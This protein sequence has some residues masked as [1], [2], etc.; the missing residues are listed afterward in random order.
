MSLAILIV[1]LVALVGAIVCMALAMF[2]A[3]GMIRGIR[4]SSEWWVNLIPFIAF[5]LPGALDAA[6]QIHRAKFVRWFFLAVA[7]ALLV[8]LLQYMLGQA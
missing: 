1:A 8:V 4:A 5:A 3:F 7:L 2:H 6:G